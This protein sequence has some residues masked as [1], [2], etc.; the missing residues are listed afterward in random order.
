ML[1]SFPIIA[2]LRIA[3]RPK[4]LELTIKKSFEAAKQTDYRYFAVDPVNYN[5][6]VFN[7]YELAKK[8]I[9]TAPP[10]Q[11]EFYIID[12]GA[13]MGGFLDGLGNYL[14]AVQLPEDIKVNLI[15]LT[16]Q[17]KIPYEKQE[18][19]KNCIKYLFGKFNAENFNEKLVRLSAAGLDIKNKID[20]AVSRLTFIHLADPLGTLIQIYDNLRPGR[21]MMFFDFFMVNLKISE[22]KGFKKTII[23]NILPLTNAEFI[24]SSAAPAAIES[25][26]F[27]IRRNKD[28]LILPLHYGPI[29]DFANYNSGEWPRA[30]YG[31]EPGVNLPAIDLSHDNAFQ[32]T[33]H[34]SK[35]SQPLYNWLIQNTSLKYSKWQSIL[36]EDNYPKKQT[37]EDMVFDTLDEN[38]LTDLEEMLKANPNL[39]NAVRAGEPLLFAAAFTGPQYFDVVMKY[40]PNIL[41]LDNNHRSIM[42]LSIWLRNVNFVKK[43]VKNAELLNFSDPKIIPPLSMAIFEMKSSRKTLSEIANIIIDAGANVNIINS[44]DQKTPLHYAARLANYPEGK[45]LV[46]KL[47]EKG[48][49]PCAKDSLSKEPVNYLPSDSPPEL[50]KLLTCNKKTDS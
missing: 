7:S 11:K 42:Q 46:E 16:A 17:D 49:D 24:S 13:G 22:E 4:K 33:F 1:A 36:Q 28:E 47:I 5:E 3:D 9:L 20:F 8:I 40:N 29:Q 23:N 30:S 21:G 27:L 48:A 2:Q 35:N 6:G 18:V 31:L 14:K 34:G 39:A 45:K 44:K 10:E 15:G 37:I 12:I 19:S 25:S 41:M 38:K 26:D 32:I 43:L 50:E